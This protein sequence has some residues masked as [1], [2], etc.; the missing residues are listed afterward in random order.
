MPVRAVRFVRKMR[1]GAQ[2]HL[3]EADDG[4]FYVVK[5]K[6]NPQHR[7]IL[8]NELV[9]G[10][11]LRHLRIAAPEIEIVELDAGFLDG[12]PDIYIQLGSRRVP[13]ERG[14][15]FGSRYPGDPIRI[16]VYDFLPDLLLDK[17]ANLRE[18]LGVLVFDKWVA[19]ADARQ[20]IYYRAR[21]RDDLS[22]TE[23]TAFVARMMDHGFAFDGPNWRFADSP[24]AGLYHRS[25]VYEHVAGVQ[26]FQPW[27]ELVENFPE[28]LIDQAWKQ[29]PGEWFD[30]DESEF[31]ALLT[32]LLARRK[33]VGAFI[34]ECAGGRVKP[35][36]AW[37]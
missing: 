4:H 37:R 29:I 28:E 9:C 35:F 34:E 10:I 32:K 19:N 2:A 12:Y 33:R 30:G 3:L 16:A 15:H 24:V 13:V 36:R 8:I 6:N 17:V 11:L 31:E 18:F 5:F 22:N 21:V 7:R 1:G 25:N 14:W 23:R 26:D 20:C 27:L